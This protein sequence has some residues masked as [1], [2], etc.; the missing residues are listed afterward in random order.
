V[1][2]LLIC[3]NENSLLFSRVIF[4]HHKN[5]LK[6]VISF[7]RVFVY[8]TRSSML[9]HYTCFRVLYTYVI[10]FKPIPNGAKVLNIIILISVFNGHIHLDMLI[11]LVI[12]IL[13]WKTL[14]KHRRTSGIKNRRA[15]C[16]LLACC[17]SNKYVYTNQTQC[18]QDAQ[19]RQ[20]LL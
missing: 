9:F 10:S 11:K 18:C 15:T 8:F 17:L 16:K 5:I 19:Q 12:S 20:I 4:N 13:K 14:L 1:R 7:T 3:L 2:L 6:Y